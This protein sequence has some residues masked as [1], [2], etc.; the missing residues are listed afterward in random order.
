M[1]ITNKDRTV[2]MAAGDVLLVKLPARL[3]TGYSW[4]VAKIDECLL[5]RRQRPMS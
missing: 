4:R 2:T 5:R 3:G 1:I